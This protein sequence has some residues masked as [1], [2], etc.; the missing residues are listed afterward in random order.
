[1]KIIEIVFVLIIVLRGLSAGSEFANAVGYMPAMK[2]TPA[3]HL[4]SFWQ[5]ANHYFWARM[6]VF[7]NVFLLSLIVCLILLRTEWQSAA[8]LFIALSFVACVSDL[9]IIL[10]QNLPLNKIAETLAPEKKLNVDFEVIRSKAIQA[11]YLRA[12]FNMASFA[13][14]LAGVVSYLQ[15]RVNWLRPNSGMRY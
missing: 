6:P 15:S 2:D 11:Y 5:H 3:H 12:I 14:A 1:M 7:G 9:I 8:F 10:T 13:L 4:I